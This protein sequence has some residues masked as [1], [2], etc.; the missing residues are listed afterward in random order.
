M[1]NRK[2]KAK[3]SGVDNKIFIRPLLEPKTESQKELL[4][5]I[6]K[7]E[8]L[9]VSGLAGTGKSFCIVVKGILDL[10]K[11]KYEK[12]VLM[13]PAIE[14]GENLGHLP[15]DISEKIDPYIEPMMD[16]LE[17]YLTKQE[18]EELI[19]AEKIIAKPIAFLRGKTFDNSYIIVDEAQ[20][21]TLSQLKLIVSRIGKKSKI[22]INGDVTQC[23]LRTRDKNALQLH[24]DLF[25]NYH[26][27][28]GTFVFDPTHLVRNELIGF[29]LDRIDATTN[30]SDYKYDK[31][32]R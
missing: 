7:K 12:I 10:L 16:I 26:S 30:Q 18:I 14:A 24:I 29:Y 28:I 3:S 21:C 9:F 1:S 11:G 15:G 8:I 22:I 5:L 25:E 17:K 13:R 23:D 2:I 27:K 20:N 6:D 32:Q 19:R 4:E 31:D